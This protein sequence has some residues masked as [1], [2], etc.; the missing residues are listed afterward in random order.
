MKGKT[1]VDPAEAVGGR[2][3]TR[4]EHQRLEALARANAVR[5]DRSRL[6]GRLKRGEEDIMQVL[7]SPPPCVHTAKVAEI[8]MALPKV[9]P[10]RASRILEECRISSTKTIIGLTPRQR[11]ELI[12]RL[13]RLH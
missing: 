8:L 1:Q 3:P 10:V 11:N 4:T 13:A 6:K 7:M 2:V 12:A 5:V 9:G